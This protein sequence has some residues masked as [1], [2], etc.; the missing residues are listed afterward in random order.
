MFALG[1]DRR[2]ARFAGATSMAWLCA[3]AIATAQVPTANAQTV[4]AQT[5]ES[6]SSAAQVDAATTTAGDETVAQPTANDSADSNAPLLVEPENATAGETE[7]GASADSNASSD[8]GESSGENDTQ[9]AETASEAEGATPSSNE[10]EVA[11]A[12][13]EP[14]AAESEAGMPTYQKLLIVAAVFLV[15]IFLGQYLSQVTKLPDHGWKFTLAMIAVAV[16]LSAT[17]TGW[18]PKLGPD[19]SGGLI[20]VYEVDREAMEDPSANVNMDEVV[21]AVMR[22]VNPAG[23][24]E[25]TVRP[26]NVD[27]I[28]IIIPK[29]DQAE[30]ARIKSIITSTG[31]L[32]FRI[33][34]NTRDHADDIEEM[35]SSPDRRRFRTLEDGTE[36]LIAKWVP[37]RKGKESEWADRPGFA[38]RRNQRGELEILVMGDEFDVTGQYLSSARAGVDELGNP[39]VHFTFDAKGSRLFGELTRLNLPDPV[40]EFQRQLG[41]ILDGQLYS[42]PNIRSAIYGN[43]EITGTGTAQETEDLASVLTAGRLPAALRK[44]PNSSWFTGPTLGMDTIRKGSVSMVV[45]LAVVML[46]MAFYYRFSGVVACVSLVLNIILV[47]G[48]MIMFSA[49]FTLPGLAGLVLTV[50]MAVDAN[51]LIFE[52]IREE[53]LRGAA[54]RMAIRNGFERA[55]TTIVDANLTTLITAVVLYSIGTDQVKGFAVTLILGI[56]MSMFTAIFCSR[57]IFDVFERM[58]WVK[59]LKMFQIVSDA[60]VD[61]VSLFKPA[62]VASALIIV[63]G[64]VGVVLRGKGLLDIDFTGGASVMIQFEEGQEMEIDE[65]RLAVEDLPDVTVVNVP[66][67]DQSPNLVYQINTSLEDVGEVENIFEEK[68]AGKL[69]SNHVTFT[70]P[71]EFEGSGATPNGDDATAVTTVVDPFSEGGSTAELAFSSPIAHDDLMAELGKDWYFELSNPDYTAGSSAPFDSWTVKAPLPPAEAVALFESVQQ[72]FAERPFFPMSNEI[73][74]R[75]AG[76]MQQRAVAAILASLLFVVGY[77]WLRFQKI[78]FGLAAVVALV[79]DV[80]ITLGVLALSFWLSNVF[81]FL[82]IEPFKISL[83]IVAAF[84]TLVGYSLND[85]IVVFDRIREVRGKSP[86]ITGDMINT[87]INQTLGRTLLTSLTT[88]FVVMILYAAG[89]PGVHGFAFVLVVGILVGTYSSVFVASPLLL[90]LNRESVPASASRGIKRSGVAEPTA[91]G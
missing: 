45:S 78:V 9:D 41:I 28:E 88:L 80:L 81:G 84:L 23:L 43:G 46:F 11:V 5:G 17:I 87:S 48:F 57:L 26:V 25:V 90:W 66:I 22:R 19:L 73:G 75:V 76:A 69:A 60:R 50:G 91:S 77:I 3:M 65:V 89:G 36:Q 20:M 83:P 6:G 10:S 38:T 35:R 67:A 86:G 42:A 27:Q 40:Q 31:A 2:I 13:S 54:L 55:T 29:A 71:S 1:V 85:T 14:A 64:V 18:P 16:G 8:S 21:P 52:R 34:A 72:R 37:V 63:V 4:N 59:T 61:F 44:E 47:L 70:Q 82:L 58:R 79:H 24:K 39:S 62:M 74:G 33:V 51:V 15:P 7:S 30:L 49:A 68:F 12:D 32:E 56:L 53:T